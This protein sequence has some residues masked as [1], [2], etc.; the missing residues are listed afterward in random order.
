MIGKMIKSLNSINPFS[1]KFIMFGCI[2]VLM[3]CIAGVSLIAYNSNFVHEVNLHLIG[4]SMISTSCVVFTQIVIGGLIMDFFNTL[5]Q[6]R[7]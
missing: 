7:D 5:I 3:L 6:N 4:S 1:K 2:P